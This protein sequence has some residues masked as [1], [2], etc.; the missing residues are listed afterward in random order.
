MRQPRAP[1][2][3]VTGLG[4]V[5]CFY[6]RRRRFQLPSI[7]G[8]I[9]SPC[10]FCV[11]DRLARVLAFERGLARSMACRSACRSRRAAGVLVSASSTRFAFGGWNGGPAASRPIK[12][13]PFR[14]GRTFPTRRPYMNTLPSG[15]NRLH[16]IRQHL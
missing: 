14:F 12:V 15:V 2:H 1:V 3:S 4:V 6:T 11:S 8:R 16:L 7:F 13:Q 5:V 9:A 10:Q